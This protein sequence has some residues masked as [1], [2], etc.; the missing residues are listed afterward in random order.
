MIQQGKAD[1]YVKIAASGKGGTY[2]NPSCGKCRSLS[3]LTLVQ[4]NMQGYVPCSVCG[5]EPQFYLKSG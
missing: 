1:M 3:R 2:H 4:A 5:G